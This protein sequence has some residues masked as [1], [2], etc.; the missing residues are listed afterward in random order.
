MALALRRSAY[1]TNIETR[2]D[3]SCC[4]FDGNLRPIAQSFSQPNHLGS[5]VGTVRQAVLDYGAE[6]LGPGDHLVVNYPYPSG[7]HLNDIVMVVSAPHRVAPRSFS[8]APA[9]VDK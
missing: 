6:N 9:R 2:C 5:M 8:T 1:S 7:A 4:L 3:F